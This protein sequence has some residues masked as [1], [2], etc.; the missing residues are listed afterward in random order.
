MDAAALV[1]RKTQSAAICSVVTNC[2]VGCACRSTFL[3][4]SSALMRRALAVS[5]IADESSRHGHFLALLDDRAL[6]LGHSLM[7][8][9][10]LMHGNLLHMQR[11]S[12]L[13]AP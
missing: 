3:T 13:D 5:G 10:G 7:F 2:R 8:R 11:R 1:Q 9:G 12:Y 4:T 6:G